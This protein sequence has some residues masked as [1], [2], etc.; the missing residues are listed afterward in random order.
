MNKEKV[1]YPESGAY[2][3]SLLRG[4]NFINSIF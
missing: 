3:A 4:Y 1:I 2:G